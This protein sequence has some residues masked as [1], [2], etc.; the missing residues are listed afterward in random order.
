ME[1]TTRQSVWHAHMGKVWHVLVPLLLLSIKTLMLAV[2][3]HPICC[4][5]GRE[6]SRQFDSILDEVRRL[7]DSG[8]KEVTLLG[9]NVN[10]YADFSSSP[11]PPSCQSASAERWYAEGFQSVYKPNREG[12]LVFADLL[13]AC[14]SLNG[15]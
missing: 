12:A 9:Q 6:R 7:S 15:L 8:M 14:A 1:R 5:S 10:S 11:G 13:D 2:C 3:Q 4:C